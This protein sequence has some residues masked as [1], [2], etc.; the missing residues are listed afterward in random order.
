M[1]TATPQQLRELAE[2]KEYHFGSADE[3][4]E[5]VDHGYSD[6]RFWQGIGTEQETLSYRE[7]REIAIKGL[8]EEFK[9]DGFGHETLTAWCETGLKLAQDLYDQAITA[10]PTAYHGA[11]AGEGHIEMVMTNALLT[12][13]ALKRAA[14]SFDGLTPKQQQMIDSRFW[15]KETVDKISPAEV[16][17]IIAYS[18]FHEAGE[19]WPRMV[20]LKKL[21]A[22]RRQLES[23]LADFFKDDPEN[24]PILKNWVIKIR[25]E[26]KD[27][28]GT[29][30]GYDLVNE[31]KVGQES[32]FFTEDIP[33]AGFIDLQGKRSWVETSFRISLD[34]EADEKDISFNSELSRPAKNETDK[35]R[36]ALAQ[37]TRAADLM[38]SLD[39][40][41]QQKVIVGDKQTTLGSA[42]LYAEFLRYM[43][44]ALPSYGWTKGILSA[45]TDPFFV[46]VILEKLNLPLTL[47]QL[48]DQFVIDRDHPD[49]KGVYIQSLKN[50]RALAG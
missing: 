10:S 5:F 14:K 39:A 33:S 21:P 4:L 48:L 44:H 3:L 43:P 16:K 46:N 19:W 32:L 31:F 9:D 12:T 22:Y 50:L 24:S 47:V 2:Q 34:E 23:S 45:G 15:G 13:L 38:Q 42:L 26:I 36:I 8:S 35:K 25:D 41:Y 7:L 18:V 27:E 28:T 30:T 11:A 49:L 37:I 40:N 17:K 1:E 20:P 6:S 29:V